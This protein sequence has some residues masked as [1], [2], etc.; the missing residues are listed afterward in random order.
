MLVF[1]IDRMLEWLFGLISC[2]DH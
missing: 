1:E 2:S